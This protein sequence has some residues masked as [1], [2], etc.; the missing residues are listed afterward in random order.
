MS[1]ETPAALAVGDERTE[2]HHSAGIRSLCHHLRTAVTGAQISTDIAS[3]VAHKFITS[4]NE[5]GSIMES[6][7]GQTVLNDKPMMSYDCELAFGHSC[8]MATNPPKSDHKAAFL[9]RTKAARG[10]RTQ[11]TMAELLE[12]KQDKYKQYEIRS[13]MPHDLI[14][15]FLKITG[16]TWEWLFEGKGQGPAVLVKPP[17][18]KPQKK[19]GKRAA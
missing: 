9:A 7:L 4:L 1:E 2:T 12:I 15:R 8:D 5:V 11:E 14:P 19:K 10:A 6:D 17:E 18:A 16:V 3:S 13:Y